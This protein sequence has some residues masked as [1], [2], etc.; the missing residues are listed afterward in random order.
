MTEEPINT[1]DTPPSPFNP[2]D[3][4]SLLDFFEKS[5]TRPIKGDRI[6]EKLGIAEAQRADLNGALEALV[7]D[8]KIV[9]TRDKR[10]GLPARM[11]LVVGSL[12]CHEKG[13]G[14][15]VPRDLG[16]ADLYIPRHKLGDAM[17]GDVVV[18][19]QVSRVAG[20]RP[21]GASFAFCGA[22]APRSSARS[23]GAVASPTSF[24]L[25]FASATRSTL[26]RVT[27]ATPSRGKSYVP[28]SP[29]IPRVTVVVTRRVVSSR[30]WAMPTI[31]RSTSR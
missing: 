7:A 8:G 15:V 1:A 22:L 29:N 30:F 24:R 23:S 10:Y 28:R 19:R 20:A 5:A 21:R 4:R 12:T 6:A 16:Q 2:A 25:T 17:H 26:P 27:S 3:T 31:R 11:N 9:E 14:F 13:F 18:A